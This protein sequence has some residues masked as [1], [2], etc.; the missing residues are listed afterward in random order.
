MQDGRGREVDLHPL[1]FDSAGDGW[2]QL[3]A[4]GMAWDR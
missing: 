1:I 3:S 4:S 2:Q